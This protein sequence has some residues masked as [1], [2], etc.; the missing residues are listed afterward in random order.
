MRLELAVE[1]GA[2]QA[3]AP[4][5]AAGAAVEHR[6]GFHLIGRAVLSG[7]QQQ[8]FRET[9]LGGGSVLLI[10]AITTADLA[11]SPVARRSPQSSVTFCVA[12]RVTGLSFPDRS[13]RG[14][15]P[16]ALSIS[17]SYS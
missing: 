9:G 5:S 16:T 7:E 8:R 1:L 15:V 11:R 10:K 14:P 4:L 6:L 13:V 2:G 3:V 17:F 12:G